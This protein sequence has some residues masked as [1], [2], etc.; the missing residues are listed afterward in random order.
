MGL[1]PRI[2]GTD[3][4]T[5]PTAFRS[6]IRVSQQAH[7]PEGGGAACSRVSVARRMVLAEQACQHAALGEDEHQPRGQ[8]SA[9]YLQTT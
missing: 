1:A 2:P 6:R 4:E 8:G 3:L 9:P 7:R 5:R